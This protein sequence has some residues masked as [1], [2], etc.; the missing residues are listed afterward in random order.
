M[1]TRLNKGRLKFTLKFTL[2]PDI[3]SE[4]AASVS[5]NVPM[6]S[7]LTHTHTHS[8]TIHKH[9]L[10]THMLQ[11]HTDLR[12][13]LK[14]GETQTSS[15]EASKSASVLCHRVCVCVCASAFQRGHRGPANPCEQPSNGPM[16]T[17]HT[18]QS[19]DHKHTF[20]HTPVVESNTNWLHTDVSERKCPA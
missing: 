18:E 6:N 3:S 4:D 19:Q 5:T 17:P 14:S 9:T 15:R 1:H 12:G 8:T 20:T 16:V 7:Y 11:E 10:H 13:F 2:S